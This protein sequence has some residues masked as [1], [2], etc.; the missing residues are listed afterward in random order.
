MH[1]LLL[2]LA[3]LAVPTVPFQK[4]VVTPAT[5]LFVLEAGGDVQ[6]LRAFEGS[7]QRAI[8]A[9]TSASG[10]AAAVA[11][12]PPVVSTSVRVPLLPAG[13]LRTVLE[14]A[15][16]GGAAGA[17]TVREVD[18][19]GQEVFVHQLE[20][21]RL[22]TLDLSGY[23]ASSKE[24]PEW[25]AGFDVAVAK[26]AAGSQSKVATA[27]KSKAIA[28]GGVRLLLEGKEIQKLFSVEGLHFEFAV[29]S[30]SASSKVSAPA[31]LPAPLRVRLIGNEVKPWID[32]LGKA[33]S[34][35]EIELLDTSGSKPAVVGRVTFQDAQLV[36]VGRPGDTDFESIELEFRC[37]G[38]R[39][40]FSPAP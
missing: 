38:P 17:W 35:L 34:G 3:L 12:T 5:R 21:V 7:A 28:R 11:K 32:L 10:G 31:S 24:P 19:Q 14:Q 4:G 13:G 9:A 22:R 18:L 20:G 2:P 30:S 15:F 25:H 23:E 16:V 1:A 40:S 36:A 37:S 29:A 26:L 39:L 8:V 6:I 27:A 33:A